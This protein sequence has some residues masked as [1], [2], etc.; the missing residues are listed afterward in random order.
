MYSAVILAGGFGTRLKPVTDTLPK[1]ML[2]VFGEPNIVRITELLCKNGFDSAV[3]TLKYLPEKITGALGDMSRGVD[4]YYTFEDEP[5]GTAGAIKAAAPLLCG[6]FPVIS[7]DSVCDFDLAAAYEYHIRSGALV[8]VLTYRVKD[9][10][11][12]GAVISDKSGRI[13]SF[14]E[15]PSWQEVTSD[16]VNTGIYIM[17]RRITDFIGDPPCD[18]S[19]DVFP[20]LLA[21]GEKICAFE[22][23]GY[24][25][26]IGSFSEYL[27]C[28][29]DMIDAAGGESDPRHSVTGEDFRIGENSTFINSVAFDS[30]TVGDN[31]SVTGSILCKNAIV[32]DGCVLRDGCVIGEGAVICDGVKLG[33]GTVIQTGKTVTESKNGIMIR[34]KLFENGKIYFKND[35]EGLAD[36][37]RLASAVASAVRGNI[38]VCRQKGED[39]C[40]YPAEVFARAVCGEGGGVYEFGEADI[41]AASSAGVYFD[42]DITV[43]CKKAGKGDGRVAFEFFDRT[44]MTLNGAAEKDI[45]K[46][47]F[48]DAAECEKPGELRAVSGLERLYYSAVSSCRRLDGIPVF[49]VYGEGSAELSAALGSAGAATVSSDDLYKNEN[50]FIL[51]KNDGASLLGQNGKYCSFDEC[52]LILLNLA[53]PDKTPRIA[54]PFF[55]PRIYEDAAK[56]RGV[57]VLKYYSKPSYEQQYDTEARKLRASCGWTYDPVFCAVE[58]IGALSDK[59]ITLAQGAELSGGVCLKRG[60]ISVSPEEKASVLRRLYESYLPY[61]ISAADGISVVERGAEGVIAADDTDRLK[62][63]LCAESEEAAS[64]AVAEIAERIGKPRS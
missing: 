48:S 16:R 25:R 46:A 10:R 27:Q 47:Y 41:R 54:L 42:C 32:G 38:G 30:V 34:K 49:V 60:E 14:R 20:R 24:W 18:L 6:D 23:E 17:N 12:Y 11:N 29:M 7:G 56:K 22:A 35:R 21:A 44:G 4:L 36:I 59:G 2:P 37:C 43:F 64:D 3:V 31:C 13:I 45:T 55:L 51:N 52:L 33:A 28:N 9:P 57:E 63:F 19:L 40:R 26:D 61:Q 5:L 53:D 15:K 39:F 8:T 58:L 50:A 1:P 62:L